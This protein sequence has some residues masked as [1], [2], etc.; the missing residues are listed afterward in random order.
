MR[1]EGKVALI[2]GAAHGIGRESALLFAQ[3]GAKVILVDV[4]DASGEATAEEIRTQG[5]D[6]SYIHA[7]VSRS[8]E[9]EAMVAH[10]ARTGTTRSTRFGGNP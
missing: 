1:L 9:V 2:T 4:D 6:A 7:D 10:A 3:E 5:G 8:D